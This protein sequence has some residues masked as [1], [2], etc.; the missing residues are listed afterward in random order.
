MVTVRLSGTLCGELWSGGTG[1]L[2]IEWNLTAERRKMLSRATLVHVIR[3]LIRKK[4]GDFQTG[5]AKL[6]PMSE[7][8]FYHG[9]ITTNKHSYKSVSTLFAIGVLHCPS[10]RPYV[11]H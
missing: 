11:A 3:Q 5:T 7:I 4:G 6:S 8:Q 1:E 2:D 9:K 10:L